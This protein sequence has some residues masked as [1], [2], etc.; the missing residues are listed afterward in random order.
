M[1]HGADIAK[2]ACDV[3]LLDGTLMSIIDAKN[4]SRRVMDTIRQNF[5]YIIGINSSLIILGLA[6]IS[7]PAFSAFMHNAGT[8]LSALNGIRLVAPETGRRCKTF[9][10]ARHDDYRN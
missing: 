5:K 6:G 8:V 4:I 1:K 9:Q 7:T 10:E 3:L 2:E